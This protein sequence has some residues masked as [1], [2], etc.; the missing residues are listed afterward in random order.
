MKKLLNAG[1]IKGEG[2]TYTKTYTQK[3][4]V[5]FTANPKPA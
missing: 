5:A 4:Q 1:Y 3:S 2:E